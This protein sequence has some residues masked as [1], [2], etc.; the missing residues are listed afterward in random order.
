MSR[1]NHTFD[2]SSKSDWRKRNVEFLKLCPGIVDD[3]KLVRPY[4]ELIGGSGND[5][6]HLMKESG[7]LPNDKYFIGIDRD[8]G[9]IYKLKMKKVPFEVVSGSDGISSVSYMLVNGCDIGSLN[10]DAYDWAGNIKWWSQKGPALN[11]IIINR[12]R[13]IGTFVLIMN[14]ELDSRFSKMKC[15]EIV[16]TYTSSLKREIPFVVD[17][18]L[19]TNEECVKVDDRSYIGQI[20]GME[21]YK[22]STIRMLTSRHHFSRERLDDFRKTEIARS[23]K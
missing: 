20:G 19:A 7:L 1:V 4:V 11:S 21:V 15:S 23:C 6:F 16:R 13:E 14:V 3:G 5:S 18:E 8:G 12:I 10:Y 22:S 9:V 2:S 17:A